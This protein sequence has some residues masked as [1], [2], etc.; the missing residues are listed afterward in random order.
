MLQ[1]VSDYFKTHKMCE[2]AVQMSLF[3]IIHVPDQHKTQQMN[4]NV[5]LKP[6]ECCYLFLIATKLKN[7]VKRS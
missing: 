3:A 1:F 7:C 5:I 2:K 4:A 6:L